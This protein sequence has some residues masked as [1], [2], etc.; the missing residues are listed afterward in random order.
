MNGFKL[1]SLYF[2]FI[3]IIA[4]I[5]VDAGSA[6]TLYREGELL[7]RLTTATLR[8]TNAKKIDLL[9]SMNVKVKKHYNLNQIYLIQIPE[10]ESV[11]HALKRLRNF[12]S[13]DIVEPNYIRHAKFLPNDPLFDNQYYLQTIQSQQA[14]DIT[15]GSSSIL[16]AVI[17]S[18]IDYNHEDILNNIWK[19]LNE[20]WSNGSPGHNGIDDD[21]DGYVD[22]YYG[23]NTIDNSGNT[24]DILGH[25]THVAGIIGAVG[26]NGIGIAGINFNVSMMPLKIID[27][28]G[29]GTVAE[30]IEAIEYARKNNVRIMN[31][32]FGGYD[33][34][35]IEKSVIESS[36][37]ILFIAS[38]GNEKNNNDSNPLY[39]A[40]YA[41][42]NMI[43]VAATDANDNLASFS[44]FGIRS[45]D[46]AAPGVNI[47]STFPG[48]SYESL[49]GTSM[50][51]PVVT[52]VAGL[53]LTSNSGLTPVQVKDRILR[54]SDQVQ[55]LHDKILTGGRINA[56]QSL[57]TVIEGPHIYRI[58]PDKGRIGSQIAIYG[59]EFDSQPGRVVF[60]G[61]KDANVIS[62]NNEVIMANVPDGITSGPVTVVTNAGISNGYDFTVTEFPSEMKIS[63]PYLIRTEHSDPVVAISNPLNQDISISMK[64]ISSDCGIITQKSIVLKPFELKIVSSGVYDDECYSY[65]LICKSNDFFGAVVLSREDASAPLIVMPHIIG[66]PFE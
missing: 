28:E 9:S 39:P 13:I 16:I 48:D 1:K 44:N 58:Y 46:I 32:S 52:G 14:W 65:S 40:S 51:A 56:Y 26:N 57:V 10:K 43:S 60:N 17:D 34:S 47:L 55:G 64:F 37:D 27:D 22:N 5:I 49:S 4:F 50:S 12:K 21:G 29:N 33:Y 66:G 62:W 20:D 35:E 45:V 54:T 38:A 61:N 15:S 31:M 63:F 11:I 59:S 24:M 23:I 25:G 2:I 8:E 30:E 41:A 7:I 53:I 18:G 36:T 3:I 6:K 19:N 42:S